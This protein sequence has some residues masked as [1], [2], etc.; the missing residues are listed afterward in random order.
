MGMGR[1]EVDVFPSPCSSLA[2][3]PVVLLSPVTLRWSL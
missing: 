1:L 2:P 3:I